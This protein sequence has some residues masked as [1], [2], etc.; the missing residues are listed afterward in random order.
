MR[1]ILDNNI[2]FSLMKPD[3]YNSRLFF[4]LAPGNEFI[5]PTFVLKE[6]TKYEKECLRKSGLRKKEFEL[7]KKE[8]FS[9]IH[10]VKK[11]S[12]LE[13]LEKAKRICPDI[14]DAHYFAVCLKFNC[15]LWSNDKL[16]KNQDK[17]SVLLT[18]EIVNLL[19]GT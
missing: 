7:R 12:F 9:L 16:L 13:F 5:A 1:I 15:P 17:V 10:F 14:D 8:I 19:F 2:L 18:N 4:M 6:F 3:S 11:D